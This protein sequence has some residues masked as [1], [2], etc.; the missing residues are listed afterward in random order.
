MF[1]ILANTET[2]RLYITLGGHL[3][4]PER[5]EAV[6]A[7]AREVA[8]LAPGFDLVNDIRDAY[9]TNDQGVE[10][11][12]RMHQFLLSKGVRH[13]V[14]VTKLLLTEYQF[15]R[16]SRETGISFV[17]VAS[18]EQAERLLDRSMDPDPANRVRDWS[19]VRKFR[20][21]PVGSD[22]TVQFT[23]K[24]EELAQ[25]MV[26]DLSAQG[27][28][29]VLPD[30]FAGLVYEG[31]LLFDFMLEHHDLPS[32][33]ITAKVV[34]VLQSFSELNPCGI[35]LGVQFLSTSAQFTQWVDAYVMAF[36]GLRGPVQEA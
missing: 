20:R 13:V 8:K 17:A 25:V 23:L 11:L 12:V 32:I 6:A 4:E 24:G 28:F 36:Y 26:R 19:K 5:V 21:I 14:R 22:H 15:E 16:V 2:N 29:L 30:R 18:V 3:Q 33:R 34:R 31:V 1:K 10:D 7:L 35:G 9:P 27:C